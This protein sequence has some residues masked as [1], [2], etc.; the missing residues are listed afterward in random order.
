MSTGLRVCDCESREWRD[1]CSGLL[2][3]WRYFDSKQ[4]ENSCCRFEHW[5]VEEEQ[6]YFLFL[7]KRES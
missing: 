5:Y 7:R 4:L 2:C 1:E 6:G 3:G